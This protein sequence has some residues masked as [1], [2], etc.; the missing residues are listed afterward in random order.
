MLTLG[1][2]TAEPVGG[3]SLYEAGS[4]EEERLMDEPLRHAE[5]LIPLIEEILETSGRSR[6]DIE[7]V[8]VNIGPGSFTG[9]RIGLAFAKGFCQARGARLT[10]VEGTTA[11]RSRAP[12]ERRVCV[13]L[14]SRRDL[15]YAKWFAGATS[16]EP[17]RLMRLKELI[18]RLKEE[19]RE[20][21][22][23]GSGAHA[24]FEYVADHALLRLADESLLRP[25][26]LAIARLGAAQPATDEL[27]AA[28]PSYVE[29]ASTSG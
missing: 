19:T 11:Y 23:V 7:R 15:F 14:R 26:P 3:V 10:G 8:S 1:V 21:A 27:Y 9:L 20:L 22:L 6:G 25:S 4:V 29:Y 13:L 16:R 17:V 28:E 18:A 12:E 24:V 2:D 5:S